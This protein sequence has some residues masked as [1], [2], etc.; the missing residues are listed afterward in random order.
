VEPEEGCLSQLRKC[1]KK[2]LNQNQLHQ[3]IPSPFISQRPY[4]L[5]DIKKRNSHENP[6]ISILTMREG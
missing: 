3:V 4:T 2:G 6:E 1:L 5:Q